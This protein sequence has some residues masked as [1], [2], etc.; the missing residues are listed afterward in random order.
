MVL[1]L[2]DPTV[3]VLITA[4]GT[5]TATFATARSEAS[6]MAATATR[7]ESHALRHLGDLFRRQNLASL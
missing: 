5:L 1:P 7:A 6:S 3:P 2:F 4:P